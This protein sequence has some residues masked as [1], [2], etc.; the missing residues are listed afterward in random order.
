LHPPY[1]LDLASS[2]TCLV[3]S[4]M[5][6]QAAISPKAQSETSSECEACHSTKNNF[7]RTYRNLWTAGL[8]A[9][10]RTQIV[11]KNILYNNCN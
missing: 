6:W 7:L 9:L 4:K 1:N 3:H 5:I 10:T 2:I 8:S 11:Q